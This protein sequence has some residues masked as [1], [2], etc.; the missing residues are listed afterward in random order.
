MRQR[1]ASA[2]ALV[3]S[4]YTKYLD[5]LQAHLR[6][7]GVPTARI[8]GSMTMRERAEQIAAFHRPRGAPVLLMSLKCGVGL[9]LT[10]ASTVILCEPWWNPF[11][12]AQAIDR[13]HRIGQDKPV[14]VVRLVVPGTVEERILEM[15]S[16]IHI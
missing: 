3:F 14:D 13:V 15:L 8:D 6:A 10:V 2:K 11:V 4:C 9:N 12:E 5:A 1:D 16:L 7:E